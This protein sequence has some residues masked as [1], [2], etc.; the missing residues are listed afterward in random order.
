M[1]ILLPGL[2]LAPDDYA[3]LVRLLPGP[4]RVLDTLAVP[5]TSA[6]ERIRPALGAQRGHHELIGHSIGALTALRWAFA[7][8]GQVSRVILLD[9]TDPR[10]DPVPTLLG[11]IGGTALQGLVGTLGALPAPARTAG[12]RGRRALLGISGVTDDHLSPARIDELYGTRAALS[13]IARQITDVPARVRETRALLDC[14]PGWPGPPIHVV[15]ATGDAGSAD[16]AIV[17]LAATLG[18]DL[19]TIDAGH[20]FPLTDPSTAAALIVQ[21]E[22]GGLGHHQ[23]I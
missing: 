2:A 21:A 10:S 6:I 1:R 5:V 16:P 11:G 14:S 8:P 4:M 23:G 13:A 18:A 3:A 19:R 15:A 22:N 17:R 7:H 9:P 20:L 12:R